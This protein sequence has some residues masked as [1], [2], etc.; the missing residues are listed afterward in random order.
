M[1]LQI[2]QFVDKYLLVIMIFLIVSIPISLIDPGTGGI[3]EQPRFELFYISI[4]GICVI[5][6]Y[7]SYKERKARQKANAKRRSRK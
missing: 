1:V 6:L 7:S 3:Q 4:A 2:Q 5:V